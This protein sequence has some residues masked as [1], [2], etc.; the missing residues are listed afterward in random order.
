M[1]LSDYIK[2]SDELARWLADNLDSP[3][4]DEIKQEF[5]NMNY[6]IQEI[7]LKRNATKLEISRQAQEHH[8][9]H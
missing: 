2:R 4:W 1:N 6:K 8:I 7:H 3:R 9:I 5:N